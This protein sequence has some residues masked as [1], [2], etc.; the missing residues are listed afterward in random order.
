[1][2]GRRNAGTKKN[3]IF[4]VFAVFAVLFLFDKNF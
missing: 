4:D 1:M 2:V 3:D